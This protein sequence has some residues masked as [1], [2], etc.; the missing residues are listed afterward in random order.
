MKPDIIKRLEGYAEITEAQGLYSEA[1]CAYDAIN[2]IRS[3]RIKIK[4][5]EKIKSDV[6]DSIP[7]DVEPRG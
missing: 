7:S 1:R 6:Y 3:L 4:E 5:L 2:E